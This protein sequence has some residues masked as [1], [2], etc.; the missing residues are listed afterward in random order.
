MILHLMLRLVPYLLISLKFNSI[1]LH[2][3]IY[4]I[5]FSFHRFPFLRNKISIIAL[6]FEPLN[7][8]REV[9][10]LLFQYALKL[11][12]KFTFKKGIRM[13]N[14]SIHKDVIKIKYNA[15]WEIQS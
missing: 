15:Q 7:Y 5:F 12:L 8:I 10:N 9:I 4:L 11:L 3:T 6:G 2:D 13:H 14:I 1:Y